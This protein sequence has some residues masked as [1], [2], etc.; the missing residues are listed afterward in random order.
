[1]RSKSV[2]RCTN[3]SMEDSAISSRKLRQKHLEQSSFPALRDMIH[4]M[5]CG[6]VCGM[7]RDMT[8]RMIRVLY[9][10]GE[11]RCSGK[12]NSLFFIS[13]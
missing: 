3:S 4:D 13:L 1:M 6:M 12:T 8:V 9:P 5:I 2:I 10:R 11:L 7:I